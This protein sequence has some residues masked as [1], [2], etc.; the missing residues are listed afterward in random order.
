M[1]LQSFSLLICYT[2]TGRFVERCYR[3]FSDIFFLSNNYKENDRTQCKEGC[4]FF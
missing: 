2:T 3:F 4:Q 1:Q